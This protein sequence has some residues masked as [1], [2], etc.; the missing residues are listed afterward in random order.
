MKKC[1][2]MNLHYGA[3]AE[4]RQTPAR[5]L[6][7]DLNIKSKFWDTSASGYSEETRPECS[8]G[9]Q[10]GSKCKGMEIM[11]HYPGQTLRT[12]TR[13][14]EWIRHEIDSSPI[15][16]SMNFR[17]RNMEVEYTSNKSD[18]P[19][20]E[21]WRKDDEMLRDSFIGNSSCRFSHTSDQTNLSLCS[22]QD[23]FQKFYT[24]D[25]NLRKRL[26]EYMRPCKMMT[27][28]DFDYT[29]VNQTHPK[30]TEKRPKH[31]EKSFQIRITF[32]DLVSFKE[33]RYV[34]GRNIPSFIESIGIFVGLTV[35]LIIWK[36]LDC[37]FILT[38]ILRGTCFKPKKHVR[39]NFNN[40]VVSTKQK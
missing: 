14:S 5:I 26:Y 20:N 7:V 17:L 13:K 2:T 24:A 4:F 37:I 21:N 38:D 3:L 39:V 15:T 22:T 33:I 34:E 29:E 32:E 11:F 19:C 40:K 1:Y 27:S 30:H 36:L 16:Y 9:L 6:W 28:L 8:L 35:G 25:T 12:T 23:E 31:K 18:S 10:L